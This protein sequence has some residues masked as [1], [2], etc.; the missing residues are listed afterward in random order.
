V[1]F[2]EE[3]EHYFKAMKAKAK[4]TLLMIKRLSKCITKIRKVPVV[5]LGA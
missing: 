3:L 4:Y 5:K 2:A 1:Y